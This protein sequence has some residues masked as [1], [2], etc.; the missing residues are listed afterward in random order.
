MIDYL[1]EFKRILRVKSRVKNIFKHFFRFLKDILELYKSSYRNYFGR[2]HKKTIVF[3]FGV[4]RS[5]TSATF[6]LLRKDN[7]IKAYNEFSELSKDGAEELRLHELPRLKQQ[8]NNSTY[9]II[10]MKPL[11]ESQNSKTLLEAF[12]NSSGIWMYRNYKD[13]ANSN[14]NKFGI[15]NGI[16]NLTPLMVGDYSNWR[17]ESV[18]DYIR[19]IVAKYFSKD[20]KPYDAAALFW[21]VRSSFYYDLRLNENKRILLMRYE[22]F[23]SDPFNQLSKVYNFI[24]HKISKNLKENDIHKGSV[25]KGQNIDL[26]PEIEKLCEELYHKFENEYARKN[27]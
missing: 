6:H 13:V 27:N 19:D 11:V 21:F 4:Q 17:A 7:H 24:G 15:G 23:V 10:L 1:I 18:P 5:G 9:P 16:K 20:M 26:S 12:P 3:I 8:I 2:F 25:E 22:S 14:L